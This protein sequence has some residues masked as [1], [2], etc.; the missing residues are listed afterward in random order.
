MKEHSKHPNIV[1][2]E[3]GRLHPNEWSIIGAPCDIIDSLAQEIS[4]H[5]TIECTISYLNAAHN[6]SEMSK[7]LITHSKLKKMTARALESIL[8]MLIFF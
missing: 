1:R 6:D 2:R 8:I 4:S 3:G 7:S 5:L